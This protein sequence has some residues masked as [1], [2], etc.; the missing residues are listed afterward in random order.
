MFTSL[1]VIISRLPFDDAD[2]FNRVQKE[3]VL[4]DDVVFVKQPLEDLP[5][6]A[7]LVALDF[8]QRGQAF[9]HERR[10]KR[11]ARR[12]DFVRQVEFMD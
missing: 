12:V 11:L 3:D 4:P 9:G 10:E 5:Q 2:A 7:E 1:D 8:C 6:R